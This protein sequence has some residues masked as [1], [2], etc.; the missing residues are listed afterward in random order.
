MLLIVAGVVGTF[1]SALA[2]NRIDRIPA[3]VAGMGLLLL[4]FAYLALV[5]VFIQPDADVATGGSSYP[6]HLFVLPVR[7]WIL[8]LWP[9]LVGTAAVFLAAESVLLAD[10]SSGTEA[11]PLWWPALFASALL[12]GLQAIF[13]YPLGIPYSKLVLTFLHIGGLAVAAGLAVSYRVGEGL[14][15]AGL[16]GIIAVSAVIASIGV[17]RARR[18]DIR[19]FELDRRP[20]GLSLQ[21]PAPIRAYPGSG[22][23]QSWYE[24]RLHGII[25]PMM[26]AALFGLFCIPLTVKDTYTPVTLVAPL[27]GLYPTIPTYVATY[28]PLLFVLVPFAAWIVGCGAKRTDVKRGDHTFHL[29]FATRPSSDRTL[30]AQKLWCAAKSSAVAWF[31][32]LL[33]LAA[34]LAGA[35]GG[36]QSVGQDYVA[37]YRLPLSTV[38]LPYLDETTVLR[39]VAILALLILWTWR[40]YAVGFWTELSGSLWLRYGYPIGGLLVASGVFTLL[41]WTARPGESWLS[42]SLLAGAFWVCVLAK[43][44]GLLALLRYQRGT[45][46]LTPRIVAR[47]LASYAAVSGAII[48]VLFALTGI[49]RSDFM[50]I[51]GSPLV[52]DSLFVGAVLFWVPL[53]R[54]LA[55]P[56]MLHHNRHRS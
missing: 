30:A 17:S 50:S 7:T 48:L 38:I 36:Y 46:V 16:L 49:V 3:P 53:V 54:L 4:V 14:M 26:V 33:G 42:F 55:A 29:F 31:L 11:V 28:L 37:P 32:V 21:A 10:K 34:I 12:A 35:R 41:Y 39:S 13:W 24:W 8:A 56:V 20:S 40:N 44:V 15:C 47:A 27:G 52:I 18:G 22:P 9:M 51:G 6:V 19:I 43:G 5:G 23:A 2:T 25:L 45:G 1:S